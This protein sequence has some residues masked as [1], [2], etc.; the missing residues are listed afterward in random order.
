MLIRIDVHHAGEIRYTRYVHTNVKLYAVNFHTDPIEL[1]ESYCSRQ[2][3]IYWGQ[4]GGLKV[5]TQSG[6]VLAGSRAS[7][8]VHGSISF[9]FA[10]VKAALSYNPSR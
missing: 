9:A 4:A 6:Q 10:R 1:D 5:V 2:K 7:C 3:N 8:M